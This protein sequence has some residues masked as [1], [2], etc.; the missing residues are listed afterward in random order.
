M[1]RVATKFLLAGSAIATGSSAIAADRFSFEGSLGA[2]YDSRITVEELDLQRSEGDVAA[3]FDAAFRYRPVE[4]KRGELTFG[5]DFGQRSY[6][7]LGDFDRQSHRFSADGKLDVGRARIGANYAF[8]HLRLGGNSFL[9]MHMVRPSIRIPLAKRTSATPYYRYLRKN[10]TRSEG[11]DADAHALGTT[12]IHRLGGRALLIAG[13]R[14]DREN[15][16]NP[17]LDFDGFEL[18]GAVQWP[19]NLAST[20]GRVRMGYSYRKRDYD[21]VTA[22]IGER[23]RENRS[24]FS[25]LAEVPVMER[26][27]FRTG[28]RYTIRDSNFPITD[29]NE[30]RASATFV[31]RL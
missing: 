8:T 19:L 5:Y 2:E 11:R 1:L 21:N 28:L 26:T 27:S 22:S 16:V 31:F 17:E 24:V 9:N 6:L 14:Y 10:F 3:V 18:N 15:A 29:Y 25:A 20:P 13:A 12:V 23:R 30:L 7:Q 4:T